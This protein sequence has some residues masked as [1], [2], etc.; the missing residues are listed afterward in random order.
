M[1]GRNEKVLENP[2][3]RQIAKTNRAS[4]VAMKSGLFAIRDYDGSDLGGITDC[5]GPGG[6]PEVGDG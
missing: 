1:L 3:Q 2:I 4:G 5:G 6:N